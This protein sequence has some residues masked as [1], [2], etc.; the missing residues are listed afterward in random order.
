[1]R[2][3]YWL[4]RDPWTAS[5][6]LLVAST[7]VGALS[8]LSALGAVIASP[9]GFSFC[10]GGSCARPNALRASTGVIFV[11]GGGSCVFP[12][13]AAR[14]PLGSLRAGALGA[15]SVATSGAELRVELASWLGALV[16]AA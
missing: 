12:C 15:A 1:K 4:E 11:E 5:A 2:P 10:F 9:A 3:R 13:A 7:G 6:S 8:A 14:A 16:C